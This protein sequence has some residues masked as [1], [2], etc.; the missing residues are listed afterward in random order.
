[1]ST[2][3]DLAADS[4]LSYEQLHAAHKAGTLG[5]TLAGLTSIQRVGVAAVV[6]ERMGRDVSNVL[7]TFGREIEK[8]EAQIGQR[9]EDP[10][11]CAGMDTET[12]DELLA[13]PEL[14]ALGEPMPASPAEALARQLVRELNEMEQ[15]GIVGEQ[16]ARYDAKSAQ[17]RSLGFDIG[18]DAQGQLCLYDL[19]TQRPLDEAPEPAENPYWTAC[20]NALGREP[21]GCEFIIWI[22]EQ[23]AAFHGA[24]RAAQMPDEIAA[25]TAHLQTTFPE[26]D[27]E[28]EWREADAALC[29]DCM[30]YERGNEQPACEA[31]GTCQHLNRPTPTEPVAYAAPAFA[32]NLRALR[33]ELIARVVAILR[34]GAPDMP[35][36]LACE[37]SL[38]ADVLVRAGR[39]ATGEW[40]CRR[41]A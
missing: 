15:L 33:P 21:R 28:A 34:L 16:L 2:I 39:P 30:C 31:A 23:Q 40:G 25:F 12:A 19:T 14:N 8:Y 1:M 35:R 3:A 24:G 38:V 22:A 10:N 6:A 18:P 41:A 36:A 5:A 4:P 29:A 17:V 20:R 7:F 9:P 26:P 32:P 11:C 13:A 27:P 37:A